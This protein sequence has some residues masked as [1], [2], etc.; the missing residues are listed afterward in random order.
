[1][2]LTPSECAQAY[3][4][5]NKEACKAAQR[6]RY[7]RKREQILA[8]ERAKLQ[9]LKKDPAAYQAFLERKRALYAARRAAG[10]IKSR[11]EYRL[12]WEQAHR[13]EIRARTSA[14]RQARRR[15]ALAAY[16]GKCA[17]CG[18][19]RHEFLSIDHIN[20]GGSKHRKS[21][22]PADRREFYRYLKQLRYPPEY[23]VLCHNCN[24]ARGLY[25][26]CPHQGPADP[27]PPQAGLLLVEQ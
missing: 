1:M 21:L 19:V 22:R 27:A 13:E 23:Q 16:G 2:P 3:Y 14:R 25:G 12:R 18:E 17:C 26:Y 7:A 5:R 24:Q 10:K 8:A 4:R 15:E 6:A 20:G 9:E 11:P